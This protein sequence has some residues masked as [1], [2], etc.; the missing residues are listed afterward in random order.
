MLFHTENLYESNIP[1]LMANLLSCFSPGVK[2][3]VEIVLMATDA[4]YLTSGE[5]MIAIA[6][7][8]CGSDTALVMQAASSRNIKKL[9]V[10]EILCKP[11]NPLNLDEV[12]EKLALERVSTNPVCSS[13][14]F[15]CKNDCPDTTNKNVPLLKIILDK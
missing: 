4:G 7:T 1:I 13:V 11:M 10:N 9:R 15:N 12:R 14:T 8:G 5:K 2:V 3:C 6:G